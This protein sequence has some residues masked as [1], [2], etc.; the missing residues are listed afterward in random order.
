MTGMISLKFEK[1]IMC[2]TFLLRLFISLQCF[3]FI[4]MI[5]NHQDYTGNKYS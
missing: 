2:V 4:T 3:F 5:F 1:E